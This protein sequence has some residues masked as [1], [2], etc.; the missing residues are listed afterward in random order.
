MMLPLSQA[1]RHVQAQ[2]EISVYRRLLR[3]PESSNKQPWLVACED[4][5]VSIARWPH[6]ARAGTGSRPAN[7]VP[8]YALE[9]SRENARSRECQNGALRPQDSTK[10]GVILPCSCPDQVHLCGGMRCVDRPWAHALTP[11]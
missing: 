8:R 5:R 6:E 11:P 10:M 7:S 2:F 1:G 4:T 3:G 9:K